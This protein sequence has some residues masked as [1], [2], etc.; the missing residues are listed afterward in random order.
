M[1][2]LERII[3]FI[4]K[5]RQKGQEIGF[6]PLSRVEMADI[7]RE[8][9]HCSR[10][11][12]EETLQI[13]GHNTW[14]TPYGDEIRD[15]CNSIDLPVILFEESATVDKAAYRFTETFDAQGYLRARLDRHIATDDTEIS[16]EVYCDPWRAIKERFK[17][18]SRRWPVRTQTVKIDGRVLYPYLT[19]QFPYNRHTVKWRIPV[20]Q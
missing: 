7:Q 3:E 19:V 2:L 12:T 13:F 14:D 17:W 5:A 20:K 1:K 15:R 6:I 9:T 18:I 4:H 16:V 8:A 10:V 11:H